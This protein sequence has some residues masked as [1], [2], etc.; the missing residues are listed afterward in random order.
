LVGFVC[1]VLLKLAVC[2]V[3]IWGTLAGSD[4]S[5][6]A[7]RG[8]DGRGR[9]AEAIPVETRT[10]GGEAGTGGGGGTDPQN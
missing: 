6:K 1:G 8:E 3:M 10:H 9:G 4:W 5:G 7:S 2:G